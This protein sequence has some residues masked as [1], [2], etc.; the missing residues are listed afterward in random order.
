MATLKEIAAKYGHEMQNDAAFSQVGS[1]APYKLP[2]AKVASLDVSIAQ[3]K[4]KI[5][6]LPQLEKQLKQTV[7]LIE[8][9]VAKFSPEDK[10]VAKQ[11]KNQYNISSKIK[12]L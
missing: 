9:M 5:K 10:K 3:A 2:F 1:D 12:G 7:S 11:V 8:G 6:E 4:A